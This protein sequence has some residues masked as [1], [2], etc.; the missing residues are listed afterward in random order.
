M[1]QLDSIPITQP[2]AGEVRVRV[3]AR[4]L[5]RADLLW[6]TNSYVE[7]PQLLSHIFVAISADTLILLGKKGGFNG[8]CA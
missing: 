6:L 5:N 7:T 4:G 3:Q 8:T 1:L 2:G